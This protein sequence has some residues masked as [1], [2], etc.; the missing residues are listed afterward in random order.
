MT[1]ADNY[2]LNKIIDDPEHTWMGELL[3]VKSDPSGRPV[4][5]TDEDF[6]VLPTLLRR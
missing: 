4:D 1:A 6:D 2:L 5:V 3:I